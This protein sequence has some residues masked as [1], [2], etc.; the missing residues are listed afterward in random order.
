MTANV[1]PLPQLPTYPRKGSNCRGAVK[2]DF[3][4]ADDTDENPYVAG[5][6][7]CGDYAEMLH[8][9]AEAEGIR[10]AYVA[11]RLPHEPGHALNAFQIG[12]AIVFID[13]GGGDNVAY[14]ERDERYGTID[15]ENVDSV[16]DTNYDF[17]T[18]YG[19]TKGYLE[20]VDDTVEDFYIHW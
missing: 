4:E 13:V 14:M 17:F 16:D 8:N 7:I 9:N 6:F 18:S 3:L 19:G 5:K 20:A 10:A 12:E 2:E 15:I 11:V 1:R